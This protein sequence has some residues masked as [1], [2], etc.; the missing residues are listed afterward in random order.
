MKSHPVIPGTKLVKA[1]ELPT[2][3]RIHSTYHKPVLGMVQSKGFSRVIVKISA[4]TFCLKPSDRIAI[5]D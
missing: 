1:D 2:F 5:I 3:F 4:D